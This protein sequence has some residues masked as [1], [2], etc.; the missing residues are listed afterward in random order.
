MP[1]DLNPIRAAIAKTVEDS[2]Y[3]SVKKL[4]DE[5][6]GKKEDSSQASDDSSIDVL[7]SQTEDKRE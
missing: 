1:T 6:K 5:L 2:E 3:L 4:L 7:L